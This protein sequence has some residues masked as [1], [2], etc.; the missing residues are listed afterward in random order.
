MTPSQETSVDLSK[1]NISSNVSN[2]CAQSPSVFAV[3]LNPALSDHNHILSP[4]ISQSKKRKISSLS[5]EDSPKSNSFSPNARETA[6][7]SSQMA[8][9]ILPLWLQTDPSS[10]YLEA[11]GPMSTLS[12]QRHP[13][14]Y[15]QFPLSSNPNYSINKDPQFPQI[16]PA[17]LDGHSHGIQEPSPPSVP[18]NEDICSRML[19]QLAGRIGRG[20]DGRSSHR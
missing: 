17:Y 3:Q 12:F 6:N 5:D 4:L 14:S 16:R 1:K 9:S 15:S 11:N 7:V 8:K 13:N 18:S 2:G 10:R 20:S 19:K